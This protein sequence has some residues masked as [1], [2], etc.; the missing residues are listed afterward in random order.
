M[1]DFEGKFSAFPVVLVSVACCI[2]ENVFHCFIDGETFPWLEVFEALIAAAA[3][4]DVARHATD[5]A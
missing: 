1:S 4:K 3:L 5:E 2:A